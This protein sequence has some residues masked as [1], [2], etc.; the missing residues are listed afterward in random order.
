MTGVNAGAPFFSPPYYVGCASLVD[1]CAPVITRSPPVSGRGRGAQNNPW[2]PAGARMV[3]ALR[4]A[5]E[6]SLVPLA[7]V[8]CTWP[9]PVARVFRRDVEGVAQRD[10]GW[11]DAGH[12]VPARQP[13]G[14]HQHPLAPTASF[15]A[16]IPGRGGGRCPRPHL[17]CSAPVGAPPQSSPH[18][19][20]SRKT[21]C[22]TRERGSTR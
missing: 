7:R 5:D 3:P 1:Y 13:H 17:K 12:R 15:H 11:P 19:V 10:S 18:A 6:T 16:G 2:G 21:Q 8:Q 4:N 14:A 22:T 9:V 20:A